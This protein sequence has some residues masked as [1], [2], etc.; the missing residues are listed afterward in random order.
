MARK[1]VPSATRVFKDT[2]TQPVL[3]QYSAVTPLKFEIPRRGIRAYFADSILAIDIDFHLPT[4][5]CAYPVRLDKP[6]NMKIASTD[7]FNFVN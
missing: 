6:E 7:F 1:N 3:C 5:Q 4:V 2:N